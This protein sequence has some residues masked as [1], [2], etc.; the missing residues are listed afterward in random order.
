MKYV[1]NTPGDIRIMLDRI[2]VKSVADLFDDVPRSIL[3]HGNLDLPEAI[4]EAEA[5]RLLAEMAGANGNPV[6]F[7]GAGS[8]AHYIPA[9]VDAL[10]LRSEFYTAYTPYQPEVSQGTLTAIFEFQTMICRLTGMDVA[11]ASMYDGATSLAE[12]VLMSSRATGRERIVAPDSLHPH[13]REVV[14]TYCWANNIEIREIK[15]LGGVITADDVTKA[16][17]DGVSAVIVQNPNFFGCIE[18]V[19]PIAAAAHVRGA[20]CVYVVTE[21][22]SLGM[23][24]RPAALGADIVCGEAASFG[25]PAGFGGPALG[26][27]AAKAEFIRKMPGRLVGRSVDADGKEA[28]VLTLQTREQHI[29]R[30]KAT[31]NICTNE[32]LCA[33]RAVIYLALV[34][35][36]IRDLARLN[37]NLASYC[38]KRM[39]EKGWISVF[40]APYFNEFAMKKKGGARLL[41]NAKGR[42]FLGGVHLGDYYDEYGDCVLVCCTEMT[43]PGDIDRFVE[44]M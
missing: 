7:A 9:A 16:L 44:L 40:N 27:L 34:G 31:S 4:S 22:M 43:S 18:N 23:L 11:N 2:G 39:A 35:N 10:A 17:D 42:G 1:C 24:K 5:S 32:A 21:P 36:G 13:Y 30:E 33:L 3:L 26:I 25:N 28:Y 12:S 15:T 19:A 14:R 6:T 29:R 20:H 37:H 38:K 8:Y 41:E